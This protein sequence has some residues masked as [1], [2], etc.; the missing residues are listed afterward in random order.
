MDSTTQ[1]SIS[2]ITREDYDCTASNNA[3][4]SCKVQELHQQMAYLLSQQ[5]QHK[6][7]LE[8]TSHLHNN[9]LDQVFIAQVIAAVAQIEKETIQ[10]STKMNKQSA[11]N[12]TES[13]KCGALMDESFDSTTVKSE[14]MGGF[15]HDEFH[16]LHDPTT[17][18]HSRIH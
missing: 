2:N 5:Q 11:T 15:E 1:D 3:C 17:P 12:I 8:S 7:N 6:P 10:P 4:L 16:I 14:I 13:P 18:L 9:N